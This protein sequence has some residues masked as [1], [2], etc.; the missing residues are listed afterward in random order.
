[1][2][3]RDVKAK[4]LEWMETDEILIIYGPRQ[5]GK[6]QEFYGKISVSMK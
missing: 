5:A 4:F 3:Q 6:I 2:F 1:M